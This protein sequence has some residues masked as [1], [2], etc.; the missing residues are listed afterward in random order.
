MESGK[1]TGKKSSN[2]G[3]EL[4]SCPSCA[5]AT[6]SR[7]LQQ[8]VTAS[9]TG[10]ATAF[11]AYSAQCQSSAATCH[12][13]PLARF[14]SIISH[15]SLQKRPAPSEN[16]LRLPCHGTASPSLC[17]EPG[18]FHSGLAGGYSD[19]RIAASASS[20]DSCQRHGRRNKTSGAC[21][22]SPLPPSSLSALLEVVSSNSLY[23]IHLSLPLFLSH[24]YTRKAKRHH[25]KTLLAP[26]NSPTTASSRPSIHPSSRP[27]PESAANRHFQAQPSAGTPPSH[28]PAKA[29]E[30]PSATPGVRGRMQLH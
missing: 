19:R 2:G 22:S 25:F 18:P 7:P 26:P 12:T 13:P 9:L 4:F 30:P 28:S 20:I 21:P 11:D 27:V 23:Y 5:G 8:P 15:P 14:R 6:P 3:L 29:L 16:L 24:I 1:G 17:D 10:A